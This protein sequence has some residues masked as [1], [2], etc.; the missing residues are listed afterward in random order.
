[1]DQRHLVPNTFVQGHFI[2]SIS[3]FD[4]LFILPTGPES[5]VAAVCNRQKAELPRARWLWIN[6]SSSCLWSLQ[7]RLLWLPHDMQSPH[8]SLWSAWTLHP[9]VW[10]GRLESR[11]IE[12][13]RERGMGAGKEMWNNRTG[14]RVD[15]DHWSGGW[16]AL[17][18]RLPHPP[19]LPQ[20]VFF[21]LSSLTLGC[22]FPGTVWQFPP[23]PC[24]SSS[25]LPLSVWFTV[26]VC[27]T[28]CSCSSAALQWCSK[29]TLYTLNH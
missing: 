29:L 26:S 16:G 20:L 6:C 9:S 3:S 8:C 15:L 7:A 22:S 4:G 28:S 5:D 19:F 27:P 23:S 10:A 11:I 12:R 17:S 14:R 18:F 21:F 24:S 2:R 1:M 13:L 25:P